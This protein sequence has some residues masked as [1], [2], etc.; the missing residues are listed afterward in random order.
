MALY[1]NYE[2]HSDEANRIQ[3]RVREFVRELIREH[4]E[5]SALELLALVQLAAGTAFAEVSLD[6]R[7]QERQ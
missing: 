1:D 5:H 6:R 2:G 4:D 3:L 7:F